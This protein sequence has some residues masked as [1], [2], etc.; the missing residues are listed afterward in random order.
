LYPMSADIVTESSV[1]LLH[2]SG[3]SKRVLSL[4]RETRGQL[5][6][7]ISLDEF[8]AFFKT[9]PFRAYDN[10]AFQ[11]E[12]FKI[13]S[14]TLQEINSFDIFFKS[15]KNT[16]SFSGFSKF[17]EDEVSAISAFLYQGMKVDEFSEIFDLENRVLRSHLINVGMLMSLFTDRLDLT[18]Y[19]SR[20]FMY[21]GVFHDIGKFPHSILTHVNSARKLLDHEYEAVML[22]P[23]LGSAIFNETF[24]S[25]SSSMEFEIV[26]N[27]IEKHHL[28][29]DEVRS[30]PDPFLRD[31]ILSLKIADAFSAMVSR[32]YSKFY[33]DPA[34]AFNELRANPH[35]FDERLV[36]V[37]IDSYL[38]AGISF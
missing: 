22:H 21:S 3:A 11:A 30:L 5:N 23:E 6:K 14:K 20:I 25:F 33:E 15:I 37:F 24:K 16:V 12:V 27:V 8:S 31:T 2:L 32:E 35:Q 10:F 13:A 1:E 9:V 7:P 38:K 36:R 19:E 17:V 18:P 26:S 4:L 34:M 29:N 28:P